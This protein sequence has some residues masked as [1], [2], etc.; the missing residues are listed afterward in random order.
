MTV[1]TDHKPLKAIVKKPIDRAPK[2]LQGMLLRRL[3][4]DVKIQYNPGTT[5]HL[6][7]MMSRAYPP[8]TDQKSR[9]EFECVNAVKFLPMREEKIRQIRAASECD[10]TM[11]LLKTTILEG[12]PEDK[13][14]L[15]PQLAPFYSM[16][17]ELGVHD[18]LVFKGERL[19]V[20][21]GMREQVKKDIHISHNGVE[22]C[23]RR[24]RECVYWPCMNS[25]IRH[26]ISTWLVTMVLNLFL[27]SSRN[28]PESGTLSTT[29]CPP[30]TAKQ[31]GKLRLLLSQPSVS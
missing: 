23:L 15:P 6:A 21:Q 30:T 14:K 28:L 13:D 2:R 26:W 20:P 16:R 17:D 3:A 7:D 5:M 1:I 24:A 4:Y 12:W 8:T 22:G 10:G 18:G 25:E 11:Q 31:M 27:L 9:D 19:V 29:Q